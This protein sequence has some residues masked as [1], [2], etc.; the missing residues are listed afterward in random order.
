MVANPHAHCML[1]TE[2]HAPLFCVYQLG[3][4]TFVLFVLDPNA[5]PNKRQ[6]QPALLGD[7]PPEFGQSFNLTAL[8][9]AFTFIHLAD[10]FMQSNFCIPQLSSDQ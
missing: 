4:C 3:C 8:N 5:N 10:L 1:I 2:L 6:R 9:I 7:H